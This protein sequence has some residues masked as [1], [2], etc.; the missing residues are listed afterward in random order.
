MFK[1]LIENNLEKQNF[2]NKIAFK[3]R[4]ICKHLKTNNSIDVLQFVLLKALKI[5]CKFIIQPIL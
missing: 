1:N 2:N 5:E 4:I 3:I